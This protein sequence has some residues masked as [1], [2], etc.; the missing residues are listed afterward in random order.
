MRFISFEFAWNVHSML[1]VIESCN[2]TFSPSCLMFSK[3]VTVRPAHF[4]MFCSHFRI[5]NAVRTVN[6]EELYGLRWAESIKRLGG[7]RTLHNSTTIALGRLTESNENIIFSF[8]QNIVMLRS[9]TRST[10]YTICVPYLTQFSR[11]DSYGIRVGFI[12]SIAF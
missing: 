11:W 4:R 9:C 5:G 7:G 12:G 3:N 1:N 2:F 6:S 8:L 10:P